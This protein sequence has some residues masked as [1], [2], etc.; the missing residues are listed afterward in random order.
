[1]RSCNLS[2]RTCEVLSSVLS[3][4]S[5]CLREVD[6]Q[7]NDLQDS[8]EKLPSGSDCTLEIF[9]IHWKEHPFSNG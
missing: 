1:L 5:S 9:S 3:S 7:N 2:G 4:Q 8:G 6:L